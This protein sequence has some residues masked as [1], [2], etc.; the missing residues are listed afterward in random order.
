MQDVIYLVTYSYPDDDT[1]GPAVFASLAEALAW[2]DFMNEGDSGM[3]I[4]GPF[5]YQRQETDSARV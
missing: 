4:R 1:A 2:I 5:V 3:D